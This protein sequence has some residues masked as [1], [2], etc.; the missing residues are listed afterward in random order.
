MVGFAGV[1]L[2]CAKAV[3]AEMSAK[4]VVRIGFMLSN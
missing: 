2:T 4:S 1:C 3:A